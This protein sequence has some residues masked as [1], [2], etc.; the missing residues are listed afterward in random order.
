MIREVFSE[1]GSTGAVKRFATTILRWNEVGLRY[2]V[3]FLAQ[4][5]LT[6]ICRISLRGLFGGLQAAIRMSCPVHTPLPT[7]RMLEGG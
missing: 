2:P 1:S 5:G 3:G 7:G 4:W 6:V